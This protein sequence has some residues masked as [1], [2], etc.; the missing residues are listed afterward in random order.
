MINDLRVATDKF[1][2]GNGK[3]ENFLPEIKDVIIVL[4]LTIKS[5]EKSPRGTPTDYRRLEKRARCT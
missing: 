1:F 2:L 3:D 4:N 5:L